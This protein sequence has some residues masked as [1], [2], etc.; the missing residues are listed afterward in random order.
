M[1]V[2]TFNLRTDF[3]LDINNRWKNRRYIVYEVINKYQCDIIGV[4]EL[5]EKM[6]KDISKNIENYN[7]VG[8]PR[9]QKLF[10]ERNDLLVSKK[11]QILEHNTFWLSNKPEEVGT[12]V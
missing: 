6:L 5:T 10:V 2:M 12:S 11:H 1:K 8:R 9:A 4:Q 3:I 7:I